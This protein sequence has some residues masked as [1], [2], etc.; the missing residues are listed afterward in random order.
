MSLCRHID[1]FG[2]GIFSDGTNDIRYTHFYD[3]RPQWPK[4]GHQIMESEMRNSMMDALGVWNYI[5]W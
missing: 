1:I 4:S 3:A 2:Y 5:W